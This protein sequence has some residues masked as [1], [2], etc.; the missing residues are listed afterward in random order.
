[1]RFFASDKAFDGQH[2]IVLMHCGV[3]L[4]YTS[5]SKWSSGDFSLGV[6]FQCSLIGMIGLLK[7]FLP[8]RCDSLSLSLDQFSRMSSLLNILI[9]F[10]RPP[11]RC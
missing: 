9:T 8:P 7:A 2:M 5:L 10:S 11:S 3:A 6:P 1:M 4:V